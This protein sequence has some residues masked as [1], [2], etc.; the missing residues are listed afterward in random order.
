[1]TRSSTD[2]AKPLLQVSSLS[3]GSRTPQ[4]IARPIITDIDL[5][6]RRGETLGIVGESGSGK[7]TLALALMGHLKHGL[8]RLGGEV[9][10]DGG[11]MFGRGDEAARQR[12]GRIAFVPQNAS[13]ALT[14]TMTIGGQFD[15][16]LQLHASLTR[17]GR[18]QA[19][20][21]L[22]EELRLPGP[23][24]IAER[25]PHELSGGQ[26]QRCALG[27]AMAGQ[28]ELIIL[29]EPTT[30]L[31][32]ATEAGI[33]GLLRQIGASRQM[34][35]IYI[36][37]NFGVVASNCD[38]V[39]VMYA[40]ELVEEAPTGRLLRTPRHP[41]AAG[42]LASLLSVRRPGVPAAMWGQPPAA[43][44]AGEG[45]RFA[46]R[47]PRVQASCSVHPLLPAPA[48]GAAV[49]C[50]FPETAPR[51]AAPSARPTAANGPT[52]LEVERLSFAYGTSGF[53]DRLLRRP[54]PPPTVS[55]VGFALR[56]GETLGV[57]GESG[58][59]K[60]TLLRLLLGLLA[61]SAG[62]AR[63][64]GYDL[65]TPLAQRPLELKQQIQIVFQ[66]PGGTLNPRQTVAEIL[67]GPLRL[68]FPAMDERARLRRT[69]E[70]LDQVRLGSRYLGRFPQHLSG[71]EKQRVAIARALA[72]K[73]KLI[74]CDEVT[75]AL[76]VSVQAALLQVLDDIQRAEGT[77]Y[78]FVSHDLGAVRAVA[79]QVLVLRN[80]Q[81][82]EAGPTEQVLV[83][84]S[85]P[86]T[87]M[88]LGHTFDP[89][90]L[91]LHAHSDLA[92]EATV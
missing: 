37:H 91:A 86:Y 55:E 5:T 88:L 38:R 81:V 69:S 28:P 24:A 39:A 34:A 45:F 52:L 27:L 40:G 44:E 42:L 51:D 32:A 68:Y 83:A 72:A 77:A 73:P 13:S 9:W 46:P 79:D 6:L 19:T 15:E 76:D 89:A 67:A 64:A 14:P 33:L 66:N 23:V 92:T 62:R 35:M 10:F 47:C 59:G 54:P 43:G 12:G 80:G 20:L 2:A 82:Y 49:R 30:A 1:M 48:D 71:G 21:A 75:S 4:G 11:D 26:Q 17:A 87:A 3:V 53:L 61:P 36:S 29:D 50:Y 65:A 57:I 70:L 60:S 41:Y 18:R 63:M 7:S 22:L 8:E 85:H 74:L 78:V 16:A 90:A 58:S 25:Y 56:A 31:D 84:P